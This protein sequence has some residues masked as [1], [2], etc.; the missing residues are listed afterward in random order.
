MI[1][2]ATQQN[3]L[4]Q[5]GDLERFKGFMSS[6]LMQVY[7]NSPYVKHFEDMDS[8]NASIIGT[9][10]GM[11]DIIVSYDSSRSDG[12]FDDMELL[13]EE[14]TSL[15]RDFERKD[16]KHSLLLNHLFVRY[17]EMILFRYNQR[18]HEI[19][20]GNQEASISKEQVVKKR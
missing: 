2:K 14:Y 15:H 7:E 3:P 8:I 13:L 20:Y 19:M 4:F 18:L 10:T 5:N 1:E 12:F 11:K 16:M 6:D 17:I 9:L